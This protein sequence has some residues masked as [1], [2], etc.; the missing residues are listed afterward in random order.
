[1][2]EKEIGFPI[3][4]KTI[5]PGSKDSYDETFS[6]LLCQ[7]YYNH[8]EQLKKAITLATKSLKETKNPLMY[9][10]IGNMYYIAKDY[11]M[12]AGCFMKS[13]SYSRNDVTPLIEL[14][15]ALRAIGEFEI[16]EKGILNLDRLYEKCERSEITQEWFTKI[17]SGL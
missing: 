17:V 1:M 7:K 8:P 3:R 2:I 12:S 5:E 10:L 9:S 13:L 15:F 6:Y 14:L 11:K 16:F 4:R